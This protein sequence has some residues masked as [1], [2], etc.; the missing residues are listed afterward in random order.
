MMFRKILVPVDLT[1]KN[2]PAIE[3]AR[4]LAAGGRAEVTLLHIIETLD[5]PF[6]ELE[7]FYMRLEETATD[8][9][10]KLAEPLRMAQIAFTGQVCYGKRAPEIVRY[11]RDNATD[12]IILTSHRIDPEHPT[13]TWMTISHQVALLAPNAVLLMK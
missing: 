2:I 11:A 12:L 5:V 13:E 7:D 8:R 10:E 1:D 4:D 3:L 6:D 9:L